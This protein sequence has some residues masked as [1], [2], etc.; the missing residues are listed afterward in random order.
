M[1]WPA[2]LLTLSLFT[3][4]FKVY[5]RILPELKRGFRDFSNSWLPDHHSV[6]LGELKKHVKNAKKVTL[7][8]YFFQ[9]IIYF[10]LIESSNDQ[11]KI[12]CCKEMNITLYTIKTLEHL[13]YLK[14]KE[15]LGNWMRSRHWCNMKTCNNWRV[16]RYLRGI[17][18]A[19]GYLRHSCT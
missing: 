12:L 5:L 10:S 16:L 13:G 18:G 8:V 14:Y 9:K 3:G 11:I 1:F 2:T 19:L 6:L 7:F 15:H 4:I 17:W